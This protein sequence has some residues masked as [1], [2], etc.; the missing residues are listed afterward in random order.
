MAGKCILFT[1]LRLGLGLYSVFVQFLTADLGGDLGL[2]LKKIG[3]LAGDPAIL[4]LSRV[5][6]SR[7]R[8][9]PE[10]CPR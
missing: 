7:S 10:P 5:L 8:S 1:D 9:R 6:P 2:F 3:N 4:P